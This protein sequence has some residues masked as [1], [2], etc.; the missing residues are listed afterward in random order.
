MDIYHKDPT[1]PILIPSGGQGSD[2]KIPEARA[3]ADYMKDKGIPEEKIILEDKST[4]TY[5][6]LVNSKKIID[7]RDGDKYT[8]LVTSN[9]HVYRALR[10][11]KK[12]GLKCTSMPTRYWVIF[13][14]FR[15]YFYG[16]ANPEVVTGISTATAVNA[17][18][19]AIYTLDGRRV[20]SDRLQLKPGLYIIGGRKTVVK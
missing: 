8:A 13:D 3:M 7:E 18:P 6:N 12:I 11:A 1:P 5:E 14:N 15:L 4:T 10:H 17:A 16:S 20:S 9:Y 19:Y 2:E